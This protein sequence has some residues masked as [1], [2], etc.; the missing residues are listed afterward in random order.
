MRAMP[1]G[2][3]DV[4][5]LFKCGRERFLDRN[6][7]ADTWNAR[8]FS[9]STYALW[10]AARAV[11]NRYCHGLVL[12]AGSGRGAWRS[13]IL[14]TASGYESMDVALRGGDRP[15]WVGDIMTMSDVPSERYDAVACQQ[16]LEHIRQ[17]WRA[18]SQFYRVLKP[19]GVLVL[20]VPHLSRRHERP[21]DYFRY[22]PEGIAALLEDAGFDL[23][24]RATYGGLL[25]FLHHQTSFFFPGLLLGIPLI[26][27][28]ALLLNAPFSWFLPTLDRVLDPT[29]L[30]P[31]GVI[32][33]A[34]KPD[35]SSKRSLQ[36]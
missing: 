27:K 15:T 18:A 1:T 28:A 9:A 36:T 4:L 6:A 20:S 16:V 34:R 2:N 10:K 12:D 5:S 17:P 19:G 14:K 21:H 26:G 25:S 29:P 7:G 8:L 24:Y 33:A 30:F 13:T 31:L 32:V 11:V 3:A 23:E 35:I 22:T